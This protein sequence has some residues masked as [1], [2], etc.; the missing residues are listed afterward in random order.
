MKLVGRGAGKSWASPPA[1]ACGGVEA[2]AGGRVVFCVV[3]AGVVAGG[4]AGGVVKGRVAPW[5]ARLTRPC[6]AD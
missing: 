3:V 6:A 5:M 1:V 2:A 4:R